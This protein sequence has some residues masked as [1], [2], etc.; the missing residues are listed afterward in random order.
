VD[1]ELEQLIEEDAKRGL[2]GHNVV[3]G[4]VERVRF[5]TQVVRDG[6]D[7]WELSEIEFGVHVIGHRHVV[8]LLICVGLLAEV[9]DS[10]GV[11]DVGRGMNSLREFSLL[12]IPMESGPERTVAVD[13]LLQS[14]AHPFEIDRNLRADANEVS[15][16]GIPLGSTETLRGR[17]NDSDIPRPG[18]I[19]LALSQP[20]AVLMRG[21]IGGVGFVVGKAIVEDWHKRFSVLA[22]TVTESSGRSSSGIA[23][24]GLGNNLVKDA[25]CH[26]TQKFDLADVNAKGALESRAE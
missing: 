9:D 16:M 11:V 5:A 10:G 25:D 3:D 23:D 13:S 21:G 4:D 12:L 20:D 19:V 26:G 18:V 24:A 2:V 17:I 15:L 6:G 7:E 8:R 14:L 1:V 22:G